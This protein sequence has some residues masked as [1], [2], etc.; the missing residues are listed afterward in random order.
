MIVVTSL[1]IEYNLRTIFSDGPFYL[2]FSP[3]TPMIVDG[4]LTF[5]VMMLMSGIVWLAIPITYFVKLVVEKRRDAKED[6]EE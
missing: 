4:Q 5:N 2:S 6:E 1:K 3:H